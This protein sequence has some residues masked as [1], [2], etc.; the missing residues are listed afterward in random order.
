MELDD[1]VLPGQ[2]LTVRVKPL[3]RN[4]K[5][6]VL[7]TPLA[8][9][10]VIEDTLVRGSDGWQVGEFNLAAG[11]WRVTASADGASA[12]NDLVVVAAS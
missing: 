3:E 9:G 7:L 8:G 6:S 11:S 12:L 1:V 10:E 2:P 4:P 5:V